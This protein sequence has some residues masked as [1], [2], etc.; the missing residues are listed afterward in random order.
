MLLLASL[1]CSCSDRSKMDFAK[2]ANRPTE[3]PSYH[4]VFVDTSAAAGAIWNKNAQHLGAVLGAINSAAGTGSHGYFM[5]GREDKNAVAR[6]DNISAFVGQ[7]SKITDFKG[8]SHFSRWLDTSWE[9]TEALTMSDPKKALTMSDP[10]EAVRTLEIYL[11]SLPDDTVNNDRLKDSIRGTRGWKAPAIALMR[12]TPDIAQDVQTEAFRSLYIVVLGESRAVQQL[13]R[14]L[15]SAPGSAW[16]KKETKGPDVVLLVPNPFTVPLK[17]ANWKREDDVPGGYDNANVSLREGEDALILTPKNDDESPFAARLSGSARMNGIYFHPF[18]ASFAEVRYVAA[19][20]VSR[21]AI[22]KKVPPQKMESSAVDMRRSSE[23]LLSV[24]AFDLSSKYKLM[25]PGEDGVR[26]G[27]LPV[28]ISI[29]IARVRA[30]NPQQNT[31]MVRLLAVGRTNSMVLPAWIEEHTGNKGLS[32][33]DSNAGVPI[34]RTPRLDEHV[35]VL[36][37]ALEDSWV[38][39]AL[40]GNGET[41][42]GQATIM[43][44]LV[45]LQ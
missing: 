3:G 9:N 22:N 26:I 11:G 21:Q 43:V 8:P 39:K 1:V 23:N 24:E 13:A 17:F 44:P 30:G 28:Q 14:L 15:K 10:K 41:L 25:T 27:R 37:A 7:W 40:L 34:F 42:L 31:A 12:F 33:R 4:T 32:L 19:L 2:S 36:A 35:R 18:A 5:H 45:S 38:S 20:S 29:N 6:V 16:P